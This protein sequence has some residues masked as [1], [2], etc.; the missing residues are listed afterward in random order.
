[1]VWRDR[2]QTDGGWLSIRMCKIHRPYIAGV[3]ETDYR[4][5]AVGSVSECVRYT[6]L[7]VLAAATSRGNGWCRET[8]YRLTAVGSVKYV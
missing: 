1:M 6:G 7:I 2:L 3:R 5:T 8:D 4:L